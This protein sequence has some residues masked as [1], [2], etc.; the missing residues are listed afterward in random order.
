MAAVLQLAGDN[1]ASHSVRLSSEVIQIATWANIPAS[2]TPAGAVV[3]SPFLAMS[4]GHAEQLARSRLK[5]IDD[6]KARATQAK[7]TN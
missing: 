4:V 6:A 3:T 2:N 5:A 1:P 7:R